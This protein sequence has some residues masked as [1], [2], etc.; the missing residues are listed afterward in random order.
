MPEVWNVEI[1]VSG[2]GGQH[3]EIKQNFVNAILDGAAL[4]APAEEGINS[5]ELGNAML[6]S[7]LT[8]K[9]VDLPMSATAYESALK[10]LVKK[11]RFKK[12]PVKSAAAGDLTG[13]FVKA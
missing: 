2:G 6:Y 13:S 11:S 5:V 4:L 9:P 3:Q 1:P 8:G 10:K 12:K 7:S